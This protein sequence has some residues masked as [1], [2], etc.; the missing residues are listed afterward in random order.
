M[1]PCVLRNR[2]L[3]VSILAA[4][5]ASVTV[6]TGIVQI[7]FFAEVVNPAAIKSGVESLE[8]RLF[9]WCGQALQVS[10]AAAAIS[11]HRSCVSGTARAD[12]VCVY[13][14][15]RAFANSCA[16]AGTSYQQGRSSRFRRSAGPSLMPAPF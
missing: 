13:S 9:H 15:A 1:L 6:P 14:R 4:P 12:C 11:Y 10:V 2:A 7:C 8:T 5:N 16:L 3:A